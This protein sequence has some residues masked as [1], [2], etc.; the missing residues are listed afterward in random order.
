MIEKIACS[1][2]AGVFLTIGQVATLATTATIVDGVSHAVP[3][4][5]FWGG[6][7]ISVV[8]TASGVGLFWS[9]KRDIANANRN[10]VD[11]K[12]I[13]ERLG[14]MHVTQMGQLVQVLKHLRCARGAECDLMEI[15]MQNNAP[16]D[17]I[18]VV[19]EDR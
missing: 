8:L 10:A 12:K 2:G 18:R 14:K 9:L 11:A 4:A 5:I 3:F 17:E 7:S 13:A 15:E 1:I 19:G 16:D 6:L